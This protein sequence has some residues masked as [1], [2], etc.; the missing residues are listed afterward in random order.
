M[1]SY[2]LTAASCR[3]S[4]PGFDSN[5]WVAIAVPSLSYVRLFA[6]PCRRTP[7]LPVLHHLP[8]F[9]QTHVQWVEDA[10]QPSHPL[11]SPSPPTFSLSQHQDL[12][13]WVSSSH[14]VPKVLELCLQHQSFQW[15]FMSWFPLGLTGLISCCP[16][17]SKES[18]PAPQLKGIHSSVLSLFH[19]PALTSIYDYWKN[20]SF[21]C[22][23]LCRQS[24][25]SAF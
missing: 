25:V 19:C 6:T 14:Q 9:A 20:N 4:P 17:D 16:R 15:I 23:N 10:I 1:A 8:E 12:F 7:G 11:S 5:I 3:L 13:Q 24:N 18:S 21:D 22:M 2:M